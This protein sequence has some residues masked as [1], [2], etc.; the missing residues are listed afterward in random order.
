LGQ[1]GG[2]TINLIASA[3]QNPQAALATVTNMAATYAMQQVGAYVTELTQPAI[4]F[5]SGFIKDQVGS[6]VG[7]ISSAFGDIARDIGNEFSASFSTA[8]LSEASF[9]GLF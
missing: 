5:A 8:A 3:I 4:D 1:N 9:G 6:L 2:A 7:D